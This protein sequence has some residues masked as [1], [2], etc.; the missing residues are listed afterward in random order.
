MS[1][2]DRLLARTPKRMLR[3]NSKWLCGCGL[4]MT[5]VGAA[6]FPGRLPRRPVSR[7]T[8]DVSPFIESGLT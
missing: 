1:L 7:L 6:V 5:G 2:I 3:L 4:P 8:I